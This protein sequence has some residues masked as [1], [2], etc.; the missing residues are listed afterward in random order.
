MGRQARDRH[1]EPALVARCCSAAELL[2]FPKLVGTPRCNDARRGHQCDWHGQGGQAAMASCR[3]SEQLRRVSRLT[4]RD[5]AKLDHA[6]GRPVISGNRVAAAGFSRSRQ[7]QSVKL[8]VQHHIGSVILAS[9]ASASICG[10][11]DR[12]ESAMQHICMPAIM[13]GKS[14]QELTPQGVSCMRVE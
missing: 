8:D 6:G 13:A 12:I 5:V 9:R 7:C 2:G 4:S 14:Q 11:R 3:T 1:R 10:L